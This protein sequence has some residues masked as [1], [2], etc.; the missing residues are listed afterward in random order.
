[1]GPFRDPPPTDVL[2]AGAW[3]QFISPSA[4]DAGLSLCSLGTDRVPG[5]VTTV[6]EVT[7]SVT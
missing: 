6:L 3:L 2:G 5:P 7:E 4:A 1:M